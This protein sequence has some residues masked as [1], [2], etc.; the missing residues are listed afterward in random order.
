MEIPYEVFMVCEPEKDALKEN[1]EIVEFPSCFEEERQ[2]S[3]SIV[4]Q[5]ELTKIANQAV[6]W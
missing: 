2:N 1:R 6:F 5:M 4:L 3:S